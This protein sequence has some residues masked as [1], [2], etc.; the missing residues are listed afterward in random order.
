VGLSARTTCAASP[1]C[2]SRSWVPRRR[3]T[4]SPGPQPTRCAWRPAP[5][6]LA[7]L[8]VHG[9]ADPVVPPGQSRL[10]ADRLRAAGV[11]VTLR[12][13]R[14][15]D[16]DSVYTAGRG[17]SSCP[18]VAVRAQLNGGRGPAPLRWR[19]EVH[20]GRRCRRSLC[21]VGSGPF[22]HPEVNS[23]GA[24][25]TRV[26]SARSAQ[27]GSATIS[28]APARALVRADPAALAVLEVHRK[29]SPGPSFRDRVVGAVP[30]AVVAL[31]AA[32]AGQAPARLV[33]R[34]AGAQPE[35]DLVEPVGT[36]RALEARADRL[37]GHRRRTTC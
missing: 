14:G 32:A 13:V 17:R 27:R 2:S 4:R 23:G 22:R 15:A 7:V 1:T 12:M 24:V 9:T 19:H 11:D 37:R 36:T 35:D 10:L 5:A 25:R 16:H 3:R 18:A 30:V 6:G 21:P 31:E 34:V 33:K 20:G 28:I 29:P 8:L 26:V